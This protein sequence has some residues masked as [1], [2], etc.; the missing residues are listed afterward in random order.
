MSGSWE[1]L[2]PGEIRLVAPWRTLRVLPGDGDYE[3][4]RAFFEPG[5]Y[6]AGRGRMSEKDL[7]MRTQAWWGFEALRRK[8]AAELERY[9][10]TEKK[11]RER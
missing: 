3:E 9:R 8:E 4:M 11:G 10:L 5:Y 6:E 1:P 7:A 2:K